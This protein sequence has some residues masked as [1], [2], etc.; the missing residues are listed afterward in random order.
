M[1]IGTMLKVKVTFTPLLT[2]TGDQD[3]VALFINFTQHIRQR[4]TKQNLRK[5]LITVMRQR[6]IKAKPQTDILLST[7]G[8]GRNYPVVLFDFLSISAKNHNLLVV[9][10]SSPLKQKGFK[11]NH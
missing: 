7:S 11:T 6:S 2:T 1:F 8:V 10:M 9:A 5:Y 3:T 4:G